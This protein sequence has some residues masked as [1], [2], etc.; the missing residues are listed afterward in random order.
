MTM[1][2]ALKNSRE[3][4]RA[5]IKEQIRLQKKEERKEKILAIII[6]TFI[7]ISTLLLLNNVNDDFMN[8][9]MEAGHSASYCERGL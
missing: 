1:E 6:G 5:Y 7:I 2:E 8:D 4:R 3:K 9:C